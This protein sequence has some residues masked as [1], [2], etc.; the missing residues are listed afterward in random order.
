MGKGS[1]LLKSFNYLLVC[2]LLCITL[3]GCDS[4][5]GNENT[6]QPSPIIT[7]VPSAETTSKLTTYTEPLRSWN[8]KKFGRGNLNVFHIKDGI[9]LYPEPITYIGLKGYSGKD[10]AL[11]TTT[12]YFIRAADEQFSSPE[13]LEIA[14]KSLP[15]GKGFTV[16]NQLFPADGMSIKMSSG[17]LVGVAGDQTNI[18]L[19]SEDGNSAKPLLSTK[20]YDELNLK[21]K[22]DEANFG[23]RK[24]SL[25]WSSNPHPMADGMKIAFVSNRNGILSVKKGQSVYIVN[26]DGSNEKN[27]SL[28]LK[29]TAA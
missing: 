25:N 18:W 29:S 5:Q 12:A 16:K 21:V 27:Y 6:A 17:D 11:G 23:E 19:V 26:K 8:W 13:A 14:S 24:Y 7:P 28:I 22:T 2:G 15:F 4:K 20:G 1:F 3:T 9:I 10:F